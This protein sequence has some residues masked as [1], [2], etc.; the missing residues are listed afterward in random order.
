VIKCFAIESEFHLLPFFIIWA[1]IA[2]TESKVLLSA[3][4]PFKEPR[5]G[6]CVGLGVVSRDEVVVRATERDGGEW[7]LIG[8]GLWF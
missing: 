8:F 1:C 2:L 6:T 7:V 4:K 5:F 3:V